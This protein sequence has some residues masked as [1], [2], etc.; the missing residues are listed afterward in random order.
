MRIPRDGGG[1]TLERESPN[2]PRFKNRNIRR[3]HRSRSRDSLDAGKSSPSPP[4]VGRD[5]KQIG[6]KS[7]KNH[8][9]DR[10]EY[11]GG[12]FLRR[13][14][15]SAD[16]IVGFRRFMPGLATRVARYA[17]IAANYFALSHAALSDAI[18]ERAARIPPTLRRRRRRRRRRVPAA[19][20]PL[21]LLV[22]G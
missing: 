3:V 8:F 11:G 17:T 9:G 5:E 18:E 2:L 6:A 4:P 15:N 12:R 13:D 1:R 21:L 22:G 10:E 20:P 14:E 7:R 19:V 16:G